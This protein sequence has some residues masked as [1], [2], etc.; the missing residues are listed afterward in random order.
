MIDEVFLMSAPES[1][2]LRRDLGLLARRVGAV[3]PMVNNCES[4]FDRS[5][6]LPGPPGSA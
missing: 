3:F 2:P 1:Q 6:T 4:L 5:L